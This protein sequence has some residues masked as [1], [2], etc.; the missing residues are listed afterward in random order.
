MTALNKT[1][2]TVSPMRQKLVT[3]WFT[4]LILAVVLLLV[5]EFLYCAQIANSIFEITVLYIIVFTSLINIKS[6]FKILRSLN[7]GA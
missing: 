3:D 7:K 1:E 6:L 5:L 2:N 4:G